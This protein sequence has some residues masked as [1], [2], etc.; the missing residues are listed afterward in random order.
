VTSH[1]RG[2]FST[3]QSQASSSIWQEKRQQPS[4]LQKA[5]QTLAAQRHHQLT[6]IKL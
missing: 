3:Q 1:S 6:L 5:K 4:P 2:Q